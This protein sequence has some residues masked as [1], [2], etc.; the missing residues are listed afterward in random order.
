MEK[1]VYDMPRQ[2][3]TSGGWDFA[4]RVREWVANPES[5]PELTEEIRAGKHPDLECLL[6]DA[7]LN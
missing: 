2:R 5:D 7:K 6:D 3:K 4:M 1:V